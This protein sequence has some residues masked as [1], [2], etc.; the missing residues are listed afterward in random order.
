MSR[1]VQ[2]GDD[3]ERWAWFAGLFEGEGCISHDLQRN[4]VRR[5]LSI[6]NTDHDVLVRA[7]EIAGAGRIYDRKCHGN[8][9]RQW[10]WKVHNWPD[11][12]RIGER[13]LPFLCAR[14][15]AK[16]LELLA[17]PP[18][19]GSGFCRKGLHRIHG[20]DADVY[21]NALG[22]YQCGPCAR[23]RER[24]KRSTTMRAA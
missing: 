13:L 23:E 7:L 21:V 14:R 8:R 5:A 3:A 10:Y 18:M 6:V 15:R 22:H 17:H 11:V 19:R 16:M 12:E 20:P 2:L 4:G 9:K 1:Q 24:R